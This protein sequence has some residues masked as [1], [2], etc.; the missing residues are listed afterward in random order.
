MT[1]K[2]KTYVTLDGNEAAAYVAY[3]FTEIAAIYPITPSSPMAGKTDVWSAKGKKNLFGHLLYSLLKHL[4]ASSALANHLSPQRY[5]PRLLLIPLITPLLPPLFFC[6]PLVYRTLPY[7]GAV[8]LAAVGAVPPRRGQVLIDE[9]QKRVTV[10]AVIDKV[11]LLLS[12]FSITA[13]L[14]HN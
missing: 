2:Q 10:P 14:R 9:Y 4:Y 5:K 12:C 3:A 8:A 7:I 6:H 13:H 11:V 1:D